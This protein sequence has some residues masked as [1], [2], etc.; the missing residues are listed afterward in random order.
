MRENHPYGEFIPHHPKAMIIGSFP[1]GKFTDSK[2]R[3]EIKSHEIDFFYGGEKNL[4]WK[5]LGDVYKV[6]LTDKDT[7]TRFLNSKHLA[8]GDVIASCV[9]LYGGASD[10]DLRDIKWNK[11]LLEVIT[12]N[13]IPIVYFTSKKVAHWFNQLFPSAQNL[14]KVTLISPS[15]Q[16]V[17][18]LQNDADFKEWLNKN[19]GKKTYFF[20]LQ[21]YRNKFKL[22][23]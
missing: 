3:K 19:P 20:L 16:S 21:D 23:A 1:I 12:E 9:R 10:A 8:L 14:L 2:R 5:L 6:N 18:S 22:I 7:I 4:L 17:R 15:A 13:K 11:K